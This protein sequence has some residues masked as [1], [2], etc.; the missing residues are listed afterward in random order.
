MDSLKYLAVKRGLS[1]G[2][3]P[4]PPHR[5]DMRISDAWAATP[6]SR[7]SPTTSGRR[8]RAHPTSVQAVVASQQ[9]DVHYR[10]STY[11]A[12]KP[13]AAVT[14]D[15]YPLSVAGSDQSIS[16][17][18]LHRH[19]LSVILVVAA[20]R[21]FHRLAE[22]ADSVFVHAP[23]LACRCLRTVTGDGTCHARSG[24]HQCTPA[25]AVGGAVAGAIAQR[26]VETTAAPA[27]RS[28]MASVTGR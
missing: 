9:H 5:I 4:Q 12:V 18:S 22:N 19:R 23:A 28:R 6:S 24:P 3:Q 13:G 11:A 25:V 15:T 17:V 21:R 16:P 14:G 10:C 8:A 26:M 1:P 20:P 2:I 27:I 7:N